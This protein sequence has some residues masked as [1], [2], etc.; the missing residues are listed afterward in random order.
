[1]FFEKGA[2]PRQIGEP[3]PLARARILQRSP[4]DRL[5]VVAVGLPQTQE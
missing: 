2:E 5:A 4:P 3:V 1:L